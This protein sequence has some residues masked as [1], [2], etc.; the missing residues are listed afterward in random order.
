VTNLKREGFLG[1]RVLLS[2]GIER[3]LFYLAVGGVDPATGAKLPK[4]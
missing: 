3:V 1:A 4:L 2:L